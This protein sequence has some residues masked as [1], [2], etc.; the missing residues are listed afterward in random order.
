[1]LEKGPLRLFE[2]KGKRMFWQKKKQSSGES[3]RG[4]VWN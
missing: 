1:M 3:P 2:K 4:R